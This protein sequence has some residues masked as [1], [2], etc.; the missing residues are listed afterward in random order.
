[1]IYDGYQN[2]NL[3]EYEASSLTPGELYGFSVVAFN[4]NGEG[5]HSAMIW[6]K[7]CTAP[8]GQDAPIV[9]S[10][11]STSIMFRWSPPAD[12]GACPITSYKLYLDDG[13]NGDF[14]SIDESEILNKPYLREH[15]SYFDS[16]DSGKIFRF[17]VSAINEIGEFVSAIRSQLLA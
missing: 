7:A 17:R 3:L 11:T 6:Y 9:L 8:S 2:P 5:E 13:E 14:T 16:S 10:T 15:T 4:F 1:M 12:D